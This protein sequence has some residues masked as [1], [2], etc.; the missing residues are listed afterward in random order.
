MRRSPERFGRGAARGDSAL[1][2]LAA[3]RAGRRAPP[4]QARFSTHARACQRGWPAEGHRL[5]TRPTQ[6]VMTT[7]EGHHAFFAGV[8]MS[9]SAVAILLLFDFLLSSPAFL[10]PF[11]N[12]FT[13][14]GSPSPS[15][16]GCRAVST[17][18]TALERGRAQNI[19]HQIGFLSAFR[20]LGSPRAR[21]F[22]CGQSSN[23]SFP[24]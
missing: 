8:G 21:Q 7:E 20:L 6:V 11:R 4:R 12:A 19:F 1:A 17:V 2:V 5:R 10:R 15:P 23:G 24:A 16:G 13:F 9:E 18:C 3:T 14:P 22:I